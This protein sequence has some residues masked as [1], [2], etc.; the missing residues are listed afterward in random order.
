MPVSPASAVMNA[1]SDG[2]GRGSAP[3]TGRVTPMTLG[4]VGVSMRNTPFQSLPTSRKPSTSM[5]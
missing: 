5:S 2:T 1:T 3:G 4:R